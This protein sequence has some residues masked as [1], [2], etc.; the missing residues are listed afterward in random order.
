VVAG[1]RVR[2]FELRD[3]ADIVRIHRLSSKWF[4]EKEISVHFVNTAANR[5]DFCFFVAEVGAGVVGFCGTLFYESVGRAEVGPISVDPAFEDNGV[6][7]ALVEYALRFLAEK[8]IH[9][10]VA[11]MK[12]ENQRA[13]KF[14]TKNGFTIEAQLKRFTKEGEDATQYL[15]LI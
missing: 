1:V 15:K 7:S 10:V 9:R 12:D 13:K 3:A 6:G 4:E 11:R 2:P 5:P 8:K 14:F